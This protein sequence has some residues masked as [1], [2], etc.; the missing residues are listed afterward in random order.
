MKSKFLYKLGKWLEERS[1]IT[2]TSPEAIDLFGVQKSAAGRSVTP[3]TAMQ[4][5]AVY[6]CVRVIAETIASLPLFVFRITKEGKEKAYDH[7]LY[8][9][10]HD[11]ANEE[12]TS[13]T[14]RE[15]MMTH[16]LLWGNAYA[17]IEY[18]QIGNVKGLWPLRPDNV[19][20][21]RNSKN[22]LQYRVLLPDGTG[23]ILPKERV[24]HIP[25]LGFNGI[26]GLSPI[27]MARETIGLSLAAEEFGARFFGNG[28]RPGG[29][30]EHPGTLSKE[31]MDKLRDS[32][33][34]M[35]QGLSNQHR[36]AILEEG[37]TYKQVGIPPED[38]QF[39]ETRKFQI[40]EIA[41]I[42][43]V[44][45]HLIQNLEHATFSNIEHQSIDFVVHT[46]RPW[47]VRWEQ[48]INWKL[49][50]SS[51]KFFAEFSVDGLLRGDIKSRYEAY[52][53]ARQWGFMSVNEIRALENLNSIPN[54]DIYLQPLNMVEAG[55]QEGGGD[56]GKGNKNTA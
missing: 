6:A 12:M 49:F 10:L 20:P 28:A 34:Q 8:Y 35:H 1:G 33:N 26:I 40:E 16:I 42:F 11:L 51:T 18:D 3:I 23:A 15:T 14:F 9:V 50:G 5:S 32:W 44:P 22:E 45:L 17:E 56:D 29:V 52:A 4:A 24:L 38:A 39:L 31:A 2:L 27:A 21:E 47:I 13:F 55:K 46:I 54:G 37:M 43:R 7:P 30:L 19:F 36:I 25:G 41:R 48:A 53:I